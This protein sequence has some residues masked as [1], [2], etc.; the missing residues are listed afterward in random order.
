M[1]YFGCELDDGSNF[2]IPSYEMLLCHED[3]GFQELYKK[4][5]NKMVTV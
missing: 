1:N 4:K 5:I 2:I 3:K